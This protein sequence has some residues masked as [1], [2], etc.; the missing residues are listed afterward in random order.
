MIFR[1]S[2]KCL[3]VWFGV[4]VR[5]Q[6]TNEI[7]ERSNEVQPYS[8]SLQNCS[9]WDLI[10]PGCSSF[11]C[12]LSLCNKFAPL[13]TPHTAL[14]PLPVPACRFD[15]C[16]SK[17]GSFVSGRKNEVTIT[18]SYNPEAEADPL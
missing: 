14:L 6:N 12:V 13:C 16:P 15:T 18:A 2:V 4:A 10:R 7:R 9:L 5:Y 17:M 11:V 8:A 3:A 1:M